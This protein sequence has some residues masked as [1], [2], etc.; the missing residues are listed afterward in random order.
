M[1]KAALHERAPPNRLRELRKRRG[2][3]PEELGALVKTSKTQITRLENRTR[4]F[5]VDM[6]L[7]ICGVLKCTADEIIDL[8]VRGINKTECD[9]TLL[10]CAVGFLLEAC[11]T[12]KLKP[13]SKQIAKWTTLIYN[14][15]VDVG[16]NVMQTRALA[17]TLVRASKGK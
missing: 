11:E 9:P 1:K 6:L 16:L 10:D 5:T 13:E 4:N 8:P 2:L 15:A 3:N 7:R 17:D 12:Y 14:N